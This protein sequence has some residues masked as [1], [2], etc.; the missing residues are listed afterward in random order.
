LVGHIRVGRGAQVGAQSGV[1]RSV[2][3]GETVTGYPAVP[4]AL[5]R[6][7]SAYMQKLPQLFQR[8][9]AIEEKLEKLERQ[10]ESVG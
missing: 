1:A 3:P 2:P 9:K 7:I 5:F 6:R 8:T 10:K 4:Q